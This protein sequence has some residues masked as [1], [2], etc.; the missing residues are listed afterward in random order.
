MGYTTRIPVGIV[1]RYTGERKMKAREYI[2]V[3]DNIIPAINTAP[4]TSRI[5]TG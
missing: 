3:V 1:D 5:I 4:A 2:I